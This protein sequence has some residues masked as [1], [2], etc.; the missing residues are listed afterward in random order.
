MAKTS[1]PVTREEFKTKAKAVN[2]QVEGTPLVAEPKEFSTGSFGWYLSG[3]ATVMVD[4]KPVQ[5]QVGA[6]LTIIGSKEMK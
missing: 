2:I 3:K 5:V 4:G 6:N 1:C